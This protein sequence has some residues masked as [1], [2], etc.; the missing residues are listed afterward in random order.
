[1]ICDNQGEFKN[2]ILPQYTLGKK[3]NSV[4]YHVVY[5][6]AAEEI[7]P[8]GKEDTETNLDNPLTKILGWKQ[9][10]KLLLFVLYLV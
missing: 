2:T 3:H 7:L 10:Y 5:G 4:N 1:M 6:A 9:H 8:L